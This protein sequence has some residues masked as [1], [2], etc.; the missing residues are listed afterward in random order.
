ML[1]VLVSL[2][3]ALTVWWLVLYATY[4]EETNDIT[5]LYGGTYGIIALVAGLYGLWASKSWGF[6]KSA[7]GKAIIFLSIGLLLSEFGQLTFLYF[8]AVEKIDIPYPSIAD[9]G[10]FGAVPAYILGASFL[11]KGLGVGSIIKKSPLALVVGALIPLLVLGASYM[12]FLREYDFAEKDALTVFLDFGYPLGQAIYVSSALVTLLAT[13]GKLGGVLKLP[14]MLLV[15]AF[16]L[17]YVADFNFL[18]QAHE[19]TWN[20]SGSSFGDYIYLFAYFVMGLS[21]VFINH[22]LSKMFATDKT[23]KETT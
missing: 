22:R 23:D 10:F 18:Y 11:A 2:F 17:Q 7:F 13:F 3:A 20:P 12:F 6:F 16:V 15:F 1:V 9:I 8:N 19:G 5:H 21:L 4:P 14:T